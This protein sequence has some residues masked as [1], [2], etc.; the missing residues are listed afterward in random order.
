MEEKAWLGSRLAQDS[1]EHCITL[2]QNH[3]YTMYKNVQVCANFFFFTAKKNPRQDLAH[4]HFDNA[5]P[6]VEGETSLLVRTGSDGCLHQ[7]N[8]STDD[9]LLNVSVPTRIRYQ[10]FPRNTLGN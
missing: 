10:Y 8:N 3:D 7:H 9:D 2:I 6:L 5:E 4:L 1:T